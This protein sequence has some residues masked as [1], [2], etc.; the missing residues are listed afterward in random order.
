ML[1]KLLLGIW[2][3]AVI[4]AA[5][6]F[7]PPAQGFAEPEAARI[8]FFHVP[9][10]MVAALAFVIAMVYAAKY[11]SRR[12]LMD[13]IKS[14]ISAELGLVFAILATATGSLF[15][16]VQWGSWWNWDPRETSIVILMLVYAAYFAL[17]AATESAEKRAALS[18][19]YAIL[20]LP[21][22]ILLIFVVPRVMASLHPSDTLTSGGLSTQ[23]RLVLY[24][25]A[26]GFLGLY[27]WLFKI[28]TALAEVRLKLGRY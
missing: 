11:L 1:L 3:V 12:D 27:V 18:A 5:F 17:R 10:A 16:R 8:I 21:P 15:A 22:M 6:L 14:S 9:L 7:A 13:D 2:M 28:K 24:P 4:V 20:A 26:L 19:V 23:Y 25:A